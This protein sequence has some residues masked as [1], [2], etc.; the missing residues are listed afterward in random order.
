M[1]IVRDL[2]I[3][4]TCNFRYKNDLLSSIKEIY[5]VKRKLIESCYLRRP[6][7]ISA[8]KFVYGLSQDLPN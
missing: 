5:I 4:G 7:V 8:K 6:Q 1:G 2:I 3:C